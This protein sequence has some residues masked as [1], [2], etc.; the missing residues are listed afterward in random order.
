MP[1]QPVP[2]PTLQAFI[3]QLMPIAAQYGVTN[4]IIAARDPATKEI[5]IFGSKESMED[6]RDAV[7]QKFVEKLGMVGETA[8]EA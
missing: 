1:N 2:Y 4:I 5:G 7:E 3:T 8:W 6:L